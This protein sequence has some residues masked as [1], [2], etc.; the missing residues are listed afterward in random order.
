MSCRKFRIFF[1]YI[2][3]ASPAR[4]M[5]GAKCSMMVTP[6]TQTERSFWSVLFPR[7][8]PP[9]R[10][11]RNRSM[12]LIIS[13]VMRIGAFFP[14]ICAVLM[15]I[16][17]LATLS[18]IFAFLSAINRQT[19]L[20]HIHLLRKH[21]LPLPLQWTGHR[22]H[23][24]FFTAGRV[25][26]TSTTAPKRR[27]VAIA[28][29]TGHARTQDQHFRRWHRS[30]RR[31]EHGEI[32]R[33]AVG[34]QQDCLIACDIGLAAEHIHTLRPCRARKGIHAED[35]QAHL[36]P[37]PDQFRLKQGADTCPIWSSLC[38][39]PVHFPWA[40]GWIKK[41]GPP[42]HFVSACQWVP[43]AAYCSSEANEEAPALNSTQTCVFH[44]CKA[45]ICSGKSDTL[46]LRIQFLKQSTIIR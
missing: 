30:C 15:M 1:P 18:A 22:G 11:W 4:W 6:C 33:V 21:Q 10:W 36:R 2:L 3:L 34:R 5:A 25:S 23:H 7:W 38:R 42:D 19:V 44:F 12:V 31:H 37:S 27:A 41:V 28:Y 16:S 13:S 32:T 8:K 9:G 20:P 29:K 14:G 46:G 24:L 17:A 45:V 26:N 40:D 39:K 35:R 43:A